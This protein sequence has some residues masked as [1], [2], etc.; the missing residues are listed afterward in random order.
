M[1]LTTMATKA[2]TRTH[3]ALYRRT[4]GKVGGRFR[5]SPALPVGPGAGDRT[6]TVQVSVDG[7][8]AGEPVSLDSGQ[9]NFT[10]SSFGVGTHTVAGAYSGNGNFMASDDSMAQTVQKAA[11]ATSL[12]SSTASSHRDG[13]RSPPRRCLLDHPRPA[14]VRH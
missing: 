5:R 13:S 1:K 7:H 12:E 9:A 6:G 10:A 8:A 4:G 3:I 14:A 2:M 11:T